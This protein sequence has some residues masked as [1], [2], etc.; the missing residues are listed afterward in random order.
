MTS[1]RAGSARAPGNRRGFALLVVLWTLVLLG[2]LVAHLTAT[3]RSE[4][5]IAENY[6]ANAQAEA[7]ADGAVFESAFRV[8]N[9]DWA[10]DGSVHELRLAH[11]VVAL[12]VLS[13]TGKINP[14]I[15]TPELLASLLRV[16]GLPQDQANSLAAAIADWRE[17]TDQPRPNGAKAP[18][19]RDAG[20]DH[21]PPNAPFE[22]LDELGRVLGMTP[23][24][25]ATLRPHLSLYVFTDPDPTLADPVVVQALRQLQP[26]AGGQPGLPASLP[27]G[28]QTMTVTAEAHSDRG[29]VFT[30]TAVIRVGPAFE[31]GY[32]I[33][34]WDGRGGT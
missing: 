6:A 1:G 28:M 29:G 34:A 25:L 23:Q 14:N 11:G 18:Q 17:P 12:K 4:A 24:I 19:Y 31:R 30:R 20:L 22:T 27:T 9:N 16:V 10:S 26:Q 32:Q 2:L 5:R 15:A 13:E 7:Q 21:G 33:L 8:I 3:G